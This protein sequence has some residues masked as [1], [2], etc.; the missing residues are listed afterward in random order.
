MI[1]TYKV[2]LRHWGESGTIGP[3]LKGTL[4]PNTHQLLPSSK[5]QVSS[6]NGGKIKQRQEVEAGCVCV[7]VN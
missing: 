2:L 7:S 1:K 3:R 6:Q 4:A 5:G